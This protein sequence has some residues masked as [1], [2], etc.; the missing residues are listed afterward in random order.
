MRSQDQ[1]RRTRHTADGGFAPRSPGREPGR[2]TLASPSPDPADMAVGKRTL[3]DGWSAHE[4]TAP[5]RDPAA[6]AS[7][8]GLANRHL[9]AL[10]T[11]HDAGDHSA[12]YEAAYLLRNELER[13]RTSAA[14]EPSA[15]LAE[16]EAEAAPLLAAAFRPSRAAITE[17]QKSDGRRTVHWDRDG[18]DWRAAREH[19]RA[20]QAAPIAADGAKISTPAPAAAVGRGAATATQVIAHLDGL[21]FEAELIDTVAMLGGAA[22]TALESANDDDHLFTQSAMAFASP[23]AADLIDGDP[24]AG[25]E[26]ARVRALELRGD[27]STLLVRVRTLQHEVTTLATRLAKCGTAD[28][29]LIAAASIRPAIAALE[30]RFA[31]LGGRELADRVAASARHVAKDADNTVGMKALRWSPHVLGVEPLG[32][33]GVKFEAGLGTGVVYGAGSAIRD[34]FIGSVDMVR[35]AAAASADMLV[36]D[37]LKVMLAA[38]SKLRELLEH[39]ADLPGLV[40]AALAKKWSDASWFGKGELI[41]QVVGYLGMS[42]ALAAASGAES[43]EAELSAS[44]SELAAFA[45]RLL[46][47]G[48]AAANPLSILSPLAKFFKASTPFI[49]WLRSGSIAR[50]ARD[51]ALAAERIAAEAASDATRLWAT[52][53]EGRRVVDALVRGGTTAELVER[54]SESQRTTLAG[55]HELIAGGKTRQAIAEMDRLMDGGLSRGLAIDIETALAAGERKTPPSA[56]RSSLAAL[57]NKTNVKPSAYNAT[58]FYGTCELSPDVVF[59][60]GLLGRGSN[61]DLE[62]HVMQAGNSAYRGTTNQMV[63]QGGENGAAVWASDGGWVYEIDGTP[64]W[65]MNEKLQGRIKGPG[66]YGNN[67]V[68]GEGEK[69]ILAN[70]PTERIKGV[71]NVRVVGKNAIPGPLIPNPNYK[72]LPED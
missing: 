18:A 28:A 40:G 50:R 23:F 58:L 30:A 54:L 20:A 47:L 55:I 10:R 52:S 14:E 9:V 17:S 72:S 16:L 57:D 41:G 56:Y 27:I 8:I 22:E 60:N 36:G 65:D 44:G 64:Y 70:V 43:V 68:P 6:L 51:E 1:D 69:A 13:A 12:S 46:R 49:D 24:Q 2:S 45:L 66:G 67:P 42:V 3:V 4:P 33:S 34:L 63:D 59:S 35:M 19:A 26:A 25:L 32:L 71:H 53:A 61:I 11:A 37:D 7:A 38:G 29:A 39:A 48:D 15:A 21:G 5:G 62:S 31:L